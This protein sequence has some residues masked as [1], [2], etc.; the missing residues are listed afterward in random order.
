MSEKTRRNKPDT[1]LRLSSL[2]IFIYR[3][4]VASEWIDPSSRR[5]RCMYIPLNSSCPSWKRNGWRNGVTISGVMHHD[6]ERERER[7]ARGAMRIKMPHVWLFARAQKEVSLRRATIRTRERARSNNAY[8]EKARGFNRDRSDFA[9][10]KNPT[11]PVITERVYSLVHH[12]QSSRHDSRYSLSLPLVCI[13]T[14]DITSY[15]NV[16]RYACL[17]HCTSV[18]FNCGI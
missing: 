15:Q 17:T 1:D 13:Y 2:A 18:P 8:G 12:S 5:R 3:S 7:R 14:R 9:R 4:R 10:T 11:R 6:R 16:I